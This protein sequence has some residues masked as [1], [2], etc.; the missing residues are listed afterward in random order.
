MIDGRWVVATGALLMACEAP[1]DRGHGRLGRGAH[2][3]FLQWTIY[4][5]L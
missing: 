2:R 3:V 4:A 5:P 1:S